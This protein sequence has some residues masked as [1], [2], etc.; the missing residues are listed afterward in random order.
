MSARLSIVVGVAFVVGCGMFGEPAPN[1]GSPNHH[2][3]HGLAFD[4]PGNW[5]LK[6][7]VDDSDGISLYTAEVESPGNALVM[8]QQFKPAVPLDIEA[9]IVEVSA[10]M[11]DGA[12]EELGGMAEYTDD[13]TGDIDR[14]LLGETR[15]GKEKRFTLGLLG[16]KV[17]H[18]M[19]L[20]PVELDDRSLVLYLQI[21]DE[22]RSKVLPG[23]DQILDSLTMK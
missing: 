11:K 22:D 17:A 12:K 2:D 4:Y 18:T 7:D 13:G 10:G 3:A 8:V 19:H 1:V 6:G 16:Q 14:T 20:Y 23:F 15:K 5:T 21:P 9:L